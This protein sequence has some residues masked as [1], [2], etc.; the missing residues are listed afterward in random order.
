VLCIVILPS[1]WCG[2]SW[3]HTRQAAAVGPVACRLSPG[4]A[5]ITAAAFLRP[6]YLPMLLVCVLDMLCHHAQ[7]LLVREAPGLRRRRLR[8]RLRVRVLPPPPPRYRR[9]HCR[10]RCCRC[11]GW[12]ERVL[13]HGHTARRAVVVRVP[14][15]AL[16]GLPQRRSCA[17]ER[18]GREQGESDGR[19]MRVRQGFSV[20]VPGGDKRQSCKGE[21][22][23]REIKVREIL[24]GVGTWRR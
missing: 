21:R 16:P 19:F 15:R 2:R 3:P 10:C 20:G 12:F 1:V 22:R 9:R 18:R 6:P 4:T 23:G 14:L 8:R 7:G 11:P 17:R 5:N 13:G 24:Q